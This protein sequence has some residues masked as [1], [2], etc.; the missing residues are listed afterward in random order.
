MPDLEVALKALAEC[1]HAET[2]PDD[3][4]DH[5]SACGAMRTQGRPE[6]PWEHAPLV[7]A[8]IMASK[9]DA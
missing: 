6:N 7:A 8:V 9:P 1:L 3:W 4:S 5:C 2:W